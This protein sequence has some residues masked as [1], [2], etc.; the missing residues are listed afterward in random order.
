D[1]LT[2][3][4]DTQIVTEHDFI[5]N[6]DAGVVVDGHAVLIVL[7]SLTLQPNA[8]IVLTDTSTLT[9]YVFGDVIIRNGYIGP[10][11]ITVRDGSGDVEYVDPQM[12]RLFSVTE[13]TD[14]DG[15]VEAAGAQRWDLDE[16]SIIVGT[17][18]APNADVR[19]LVDSALYGNLVA[20]SVSMNDASAIFY[21]HALDSGFG[22][23]NPASPVFNADG[24]IN[25]AVVAL[26]DLSETSLAALAAA[27]GG[28][29][30][31]NGGVFGTAPPDST[32]VP[33]VNGS[34]PRLT[35]VNFDQTS[36]GTATSTWE[37]STGGNDNLI[38]ALETLV[39]H[40]DD[41]L[42]GNLLGP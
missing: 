17:M 28:V 40:A 9:A 8:Q 24:T 41:S 33:D 38:E 6:E 19:M 20:R 36:F 3:R 31:S 26:S 37:G 35:F 2:I 29:V 25:A 14:S 30:V 16:R 42:L 13:R 4:G 5:I 32:G 11:V 12:V 23:T 27:M 1:A 15:D 21:D 22:F 18:Y 7:G 34:T 10:E 39:Q